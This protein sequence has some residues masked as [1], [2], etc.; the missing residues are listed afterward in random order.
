[1]ILERVIGLFILDA[2]LAGLP[3]MHR[4]NLPR[5]GSSK[6]LEEDDCVL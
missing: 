1:M 5:K 3:E 4:Q 6:S 2:L